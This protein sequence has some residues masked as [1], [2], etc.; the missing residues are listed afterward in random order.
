M[1][2]DFVDVGGNGGGGDVWVGARLESLLDCF[3]FFFVVVVAGVGVRQK[4]N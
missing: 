4:Q 3:E 1:L 2:D